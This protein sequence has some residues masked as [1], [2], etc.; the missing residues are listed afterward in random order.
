MSAAKP[1]VRT[2]P[3]RHQLDCIAAFLDIN[4]P[5]AVIQD[6][7]RRSTFDYM[8]AID[9]KFS[10]GRMIPW[11]EPGAMM[12]KGAQGGSSEL[13]SPAQQREVDAYCQA[14]CSGSAATCRTRSSRTRPDGP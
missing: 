1:Y 9:H 3:R 13:L 2:Q 14:S 6:V 10:I 8:K 5:E 11:R 12:R 7:V 4:V